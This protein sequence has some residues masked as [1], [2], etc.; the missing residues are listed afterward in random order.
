MKN[1]VIFDDYDVR[2]LKPPALIAEYVRLTECDV[3][4]ML[5]PVATLE[6]PCPACHS[7][8]VASSF[9]KFGLTYRECANCR[10]LYV[11]PRPDDAALATYDAQSEARRYWR[12]TLA[13]GSGTARREKIVKPR[14]EWVSDST[15]EHLPAARVYADLGTSQEGYIAE[16]EAEG[17]FDQVVRD[18]SGGSADVVSLFEVAD[19]TS[20]VDALFAGAARMLSTGGLAF[21]TDILVSG[22]DL[23]V[24]WDRADNVF[25][26]DRLNVFSVDGLGFLFAR[27]GFEP[28]EFSTPGILDVEIVAS[29]LKRDPSLPVTRWARYVASRDD[30]TRKEFQSFLQSELLS[31]YGRIL[32]R[33][34]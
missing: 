10:S 15:R 17:L 23:Q 25:P 7:D 33:K 8:E 16:I 30:R 1:I 6:V 9:V 18:A 14:S 26:P 32:L 13:P 19:R 31:S 34:S 11:S 20:D 12:E 21:V 4:S 2:D 28:L 3:V 22:F 27:H 5:V 29:A 24:L